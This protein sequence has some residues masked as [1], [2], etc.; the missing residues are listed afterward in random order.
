MGSLVLP[1]FPPAAH[2]SFPVIFF[3]PLNLQ[4]LTPHLPLP[5]GALSPHREKRGHENPLPFLPLYGQTYLLPPLPLLPGFQAMEEVPLPRAPSS[6]SF[7]WRMLLH[8]DLL[9]HLSHVKHCWSLLI[10]E[11]LPNIRFLLVFFLRVWKNFWSLHFFCLFFDFTWASRSH[12]IS[13][14]LLSL[15]PMPW[16]P[17]TWCSWPSRFLAPSGTSHLRASTDT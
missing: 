12:L 5:L 17:F 14:S 4:H 10:L 2:L 11:S 8:P 6:S 7:I 15:S 16:R 3:I 9:F 13:C 1:F